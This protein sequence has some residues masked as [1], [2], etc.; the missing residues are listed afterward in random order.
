M[1]EGGSIAILLTMTLGIPA[2]EP[3]PPVLPIRTVQVG[4]A[5]DDQAGGVARIVGGL[6]GYAH[7]PQPKSRIAICT[8][9]ATRFSRRLGE[10]GAV[11]GLPVAT[12]ALPSGDAATIQ[13]CDLLYLGAMPADQRL[14]AI[15]AVHGQPIMSVDEA[16]PDCRS[17]AMFCLAARGDAITFRLNIDAISRSQVRVDPRVLRLFSGDGASS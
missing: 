11:A 1:L 10:A 15:R 6:I 12:R 16:S 2:A 13:G 17:G 4:Q 8:L 5:P 7:W 14:R 9:G 3:L